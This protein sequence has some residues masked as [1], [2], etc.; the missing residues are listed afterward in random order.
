[1]YRICGDKPGNLAIR[2][3]QIAQDSSIGRAGGYTR[4]KDT[5]I[6][7][8]NAKI[9]FINNTKDSTGKGDFLFFPSLPDKRPY[10]IRAGT[11]AVPTAYARIF[12]NQN[13]SVLPA[14]TG[15]CWTDLDASG[16]FAMIAHAGQK[17]PYNMGIGSL[18]NLRNP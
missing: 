3:I 6:H 5:V 2:V 9:T 4:R 16:F 7:T 13:K 14:I 1:L 17:V 15:S 8:V 10:S 11:H 12:F 18:V